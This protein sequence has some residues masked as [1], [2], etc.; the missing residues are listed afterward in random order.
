MWQRVH[1]WVLDSNNQIVLTLMAVVGVY[2]LMTVVRRVLLSKTTNV[3]ARHKIRRGITWSGFIVFAITALFIWV[4]QVGNL[5]MFLGIIGAGIALSLQ[6]TLLCI[7]S[8]VLIL[9]KKPFDIGDRIEVD[10]RIGDVI[11][12][13]PFHFSV[14]EVGNWVKADQS[15]GRILILP[16]SSVMRLGVYNYTKGFPFVWNEISTIVTFESD[17]RVAKDIILQQAVEESE[18]VSEEVGQLINDMQRQYAIH[19]ERLEPIVYTT[20]AENGVELT[21]RYLSVVRQRRSTTH[22]IS[23]AILDALIGHPKIDFAYP[24]TRMFRNCVEGKEQLRPVPE[25]RK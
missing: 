20:I 1:D 14:L 23:E 21:L 13:A 17:W 18:K 25:D 15:T 10:G 22:R 24:T 2:V 4:R 7:A 8:W 12:I 11:D 19:Y 5:G 16:N 9:I 6:E 3:A